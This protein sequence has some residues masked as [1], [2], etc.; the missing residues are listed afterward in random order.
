MK[1]INKL[2]RFLYEKDYKI[3]IKENYVNIIN[4]DEIVD[5]TIDR[6]AIKCQ[7]KIINI[8]GKNLTISKLVEDEALITGIITNLSIN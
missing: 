8:L 6:I 7:S 1:L 4:Y 5:F 2:D 3:I